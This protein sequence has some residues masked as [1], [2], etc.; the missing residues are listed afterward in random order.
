MHKIKEEDTGLTSWLATFELISYLKS[1]KGPKG[2]KNY[3]TA[4]TNAITRCFIILIST[5]KT[6][7]HTLKLQILSG[8]LIT[9]VLTP[10]EVRRVVVDISQLHGDCRSP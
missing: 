7:T 6:H 2:G 10:S 9:A 4:V 1:V 3:Q 5:H 8:D